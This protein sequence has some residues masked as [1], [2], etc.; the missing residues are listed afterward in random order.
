M[1]FIH[2]A[3]CLMYRLKNNLTCCVKY[4]GQRNAISEK[5]MEYLQNVAIL[6]ELPAFP[7][8]YIYSP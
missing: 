5:C 7:W 1:L 2:Y 3:S 8:S 6:I 4:V